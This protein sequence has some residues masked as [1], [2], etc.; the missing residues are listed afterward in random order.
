MPDR[1]RSAIL[2]IASYFKGMEFITEA[3]AL[4]NRVFLLTSEKLQE[5]EWPWGAIEETFYVPGPQDGWNMDDVIR[6]ISYQMRERWIDRI[7][8]LDDFDLERAARLREHLRI[9]GLGETRTRFFRDKL[10]MRSEAASHGLRVPAF[11]HVLNYDRLRSFMGRVPPP[12]VLKPRSQASAIGIKKISASDEIW[13]VLDALG[14][15]Q[16]FHLI[17]QFLPGAVYHVDSIVWDG[18]VLFARCH[19]YASTPMRVAHEGGVFSTY[20]LVFGSDEEKELQELN[21]Q[22]VRAF[23]LRAGVMHTEFIRAEKDGEFYFLETGARVGGAHI[24]DMV[25]ASSGMNLWKEWG[26]IESPGREYQLPEVRQDYSGILVSLARQEVP[27]LSSYTEPEIV[28]RLEKKNHAGL[29]VR[30]DRW[31]RVQE[32]LDLYTRRFYEDFFATAPLPDR[33]AD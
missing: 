11:E 23:G 31:E 17:E 14:D 15:Q 26:R 27:D 25:E 19:R 7:V 21:R 33:P 32:L 4:G 5:K 13:P 16:S 30:S 29:V 28:W 24:A 20:N 9:P 3:H 10:A 12:W 18:T 6:A 1:E 22:L 8:A 2:A